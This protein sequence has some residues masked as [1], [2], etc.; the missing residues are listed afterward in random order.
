[1]LKKKNSPKCFFLFQKCFLL[2]LGPEIVLKVFLALKT[3]LKSIVK[4]VMKCT[5]K[6]NQ[7]DYLIKQTAES[8]DH[9][10]LFYA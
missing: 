9:D 10:F 7:N 6:P 3:L 8:S 4:L 1:M 2:F 5:Y